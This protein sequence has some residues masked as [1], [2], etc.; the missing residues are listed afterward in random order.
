ML[1]SSDWAA[2][3]PLGHTVLPNMAASFVCLHALCCH[4]WLC[5][6]LQGLS[7]IQQ[8]GAACRHEAF[9][10]GRQ[11]SSASRNRA[12][13]LAFAACAL[14]LAGLTYLY[15]RHYSGKVRIVPPNEL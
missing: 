12:V 6:L 14:G 9:M 1:L 4:A 3:V 2:F 5:S 11:A 13:G 15:T 10:E 7:C 8:D